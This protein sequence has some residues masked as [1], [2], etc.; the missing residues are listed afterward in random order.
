MPVTRL[1]RAAVPRHAGGFA[2]CS[3]RRAAAASVAAA[4]ATGVWTRNI[5]VVSSSSPA[6]TRPAHPRTSLTQWLPDWLTAFE[7]DID[8]ALL[9]GGAKE[10]RTSDLSH[11]IQA[12]TVAECGHVSPFVPLTC[13]SPGWT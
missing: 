2:S 7:L 1:D 6:Y 12:R 4:K 5:C 3:K 9:P 11:A 10:I 13:G 8:L